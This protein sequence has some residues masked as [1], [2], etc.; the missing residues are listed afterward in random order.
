[1]KSFDSRSRSAVSTNKS[2]SLKQQSRQNS[3][4]VWKKSS[5][6]QRRSGM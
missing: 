1:M 6:S 2:S 3:A 4:D 5:M